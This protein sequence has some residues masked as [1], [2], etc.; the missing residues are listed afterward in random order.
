MAAATLIAAPGLADKLTVVDS[1]GAAS[2]EAFRKACAAFCTDPKNV[3]ALGGLDPEDAASTERVLFAKQLRKLN[4]RMAAQPR[5]FVV[6]TLAIYYCKPRQLASWKRRIPIFELDELVSSAAKGGKQLLLLHVWSSTDEYD[7]LVQFDSDEERA[8]M[9]ASIAAAFRD[10]LGQPLSQLSLTEDELLKRQVLKADARSRSKSTTGDLARARESRASTVRSRWTARKSMVGGAPSGS[11]RLLRPATSS[12]E[13]QED[14]SE[15]GAS[16]GAEE[17]KASASSKKPSVVDAAVAED[18]E[19]GICAHGSGVSSFV[20]EHERTKAAR[21]A[22]NLN[23]TALAALETIVAKAKSAEPDALRHVE[24]A[25]EAFG[26]VRSEIR[27]ARVVA[28]ALLNPQGSSSVH[29]WI[30]NLQGPSSQLFDAALA[31]AARPFRPPPTLAEDEGEA[32]PSGEDGSPANYDEAGDIRGWWI[33]VLWDLHS[34]AAE[35]ASKSGKPAEH[36]SSQTLAAAAEAVGLFHEMLPTLFSTPF[37]AGAAALSAVRLELARRAGALDAR[38][39][40]AQRSGGALPSNQASAETLSRASHAPWL[41]TALE[42]AG[43]A[44]VRDAADRVMLAPGSASGHRFVPLDDSVYSALLEVMMGRIHRPGDGEQGAET[45]GQLVRFSPVVSVLMRLVPLAPTWAVRTRILK[46][47]N[48]LL[49]RK[50]DNFSRIMS[51][52]DWQAWLAPLLSVVPRA[53]GDRDPRVADYT[54]YVMNF[55]AMLLHNVFEQ[56]GDDIEA[57]MNRLFAQLR[58][59]SGGWSPDAVGVA[60]SV[61]SNLLVKIAGGSK[62]WRTDMTKQEWTSLFAVARVVEDFCF[63]RPEEAE[64]AG[65][66][67][68]VATATAEMHKMTEA[69]RKREPAPPTVSLAQGASGEDDEGEGSAAAASGDGSQVQQPEWRSFGVCAVSKDG[70]VVAGMVPL[71]PEFAS[72]AASVPL[73]AP[74]DG[75][76][77]RSRPGLHLDDANGRPLDLRLAKRMLSLLTKLGLKDG[78]SKSSASASEKQVRKHGAGLVT[79]FEGICKFFSSIGVD[80]ASAVQELAGFLEKRQREQRSGFLSRSGASRKQLAAELDA[81]LMRQQAQRAVREQLKAQIDKIGDT[82]EIK[83]EVEVNEAALARAR[84]RRARKKADTDK[85]E[86]GSAALEAAMAGGGALDDDEDDGGTKASA[87]SSGTD[88]DDVPDEDEEEG[89]E[90]FVCHDGLQGRDT[91]LVPGAGTCHMDCLS[92]SQCSRQLVLE[93]FS[94]ADDDGFRTGGGAMAYDGKLFCKPHFLD[95]FGGAVCGGCMMPFR[96]GDKVTEAVGRRWHLAHLRCEACSGPFIDG[97]CWGVDGLPYCQ[98]CYKS[99]YQR[100]HGCRKVVEDGEEG[101]TAME[102]TWHRACFVCSECSKSFDDGRFFSRDG[103]P[104]C[105]EHYMEKFA[106]KC[107]KCTRPVVEDGLRACG[108]TW[109]RACFGCTECGVPFA[110]GK[111]MEKEGRPYCEE[112]YLNKFG[113]R[114]GGCGLVIRDKYLSAL[115]QSWHPDCFKCAECGVPFPDGS[116]FPKDGRPYCKDDF[117]R[118]FCDKCPSCGLPVVEGG[119]RLGDDVFHN[120]C[121]RCDGCGEPLGPEMF[122]MGDPPDVKRFHSKCFTCDECGC[123]LAVSEGGSGKYSVHEGRKLCEKDFRTAAGTKCSGCGKVIP[124]GEPVTKALGGSWHEGCLV[125]LSCRDPIKGRIFA[126]AGR[127]LCG[128]CVEATKPTCPTCLGV[129]E[130]PHKRVLER[131]YHGDCLVCTECKGDLSA[132]ILLREG[133]PVCT[134]HGEGGDAWCDDTKTRIASWEAANAKHTSVLAAIATVKEAEAAATATETAAKTSST[135]AT[136][137]AA[138]E[139][140]ATEAA[141]TASPDQIDAADPNDLWRSYRDE[142]GDVYYVNRISGESQWDKPEGFTREPEA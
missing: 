63:Y 111:F 6:T 64:E 69:R 109:H 84:H 35:A 127:P 62:K 115:D 91:G 130:G 2:D 75:K 57:T 102:K 122:T 55:Y 3:Q 123:P 90:C 58:I 22:A 14:E 1:I 46:D 131:P 124:I 103:R 42:G 140:A 4:R 10:L 68:R 52:G 65:T 19:T 26:T 44:L 87:A 48:V 119:I 76:V 66:V 39:G 86:M 21:V 107:A 108:A 37:P 16:A 114:C 13:S 94:P 31:L 80:R 28:E 72:P 126:V 49:V 5:A 12:E 54:K 92:C 97:K 120:E 112:H 141:A 29:W 53:E 74:G 129:V 89:D 106:P 110:D 36:G 116:F 38:D 41:N 30:G 71:L 104:Y 61:L 81:S 45:F 18:D 137:A 83:E 27:D 51:G 34:R 77:D 132:G 11:Q 79:A 33:R 25:H 7:T 118:L 32:V 142:E 93:G 113:Q 40:Y 82:I 23:D 59:Q 100:C 17:H 24:E 138:T 60:R 98:G 73:A 117:T 99:L 88:P 125:C 135:D 101:I 70:E 128:G 139:A 47:M 96:K 20:E 134:E 78:S 50:E 133:W 8:Q 136:E 9:A 56:G 85:G 95:Q 121:L 67:V 43:S 105:E 15:E